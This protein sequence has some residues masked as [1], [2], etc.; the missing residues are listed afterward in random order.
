MHP[1]DTARAAP[2]LA[3]SDP[4][5]C[6]LRPSENI[7]FKSAPH[8]NQALCVCGIDP[9]LSGGLAFFFPGAPA[10]VLAEDLPTVAGEID[11]AT[12]AARIRQMRPDVAFVERVASMPGQ[13]VSST[14]KFGAAY[15]C[16][17][18][19]L[20]ALEIRTHLVAP[21]IWKKHFQL[22]S[23]KEKARALALRT[24]AKTPGHFSRKRDH[25]R[26]EAALLAL[27]GATIN[28]PNQSQF[29]DADR[30][31]RASL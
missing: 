29:A 7:S 20:A 31:A 12:L 22:D 25:N 3:G 19:V 15:G 5:N 18:G 27:Y 28:L 2:A 23:D 24:F 14:F 13:G 1:P 11:C 17:R 9:G 8:E 26:A 10:R 30:R 16:I 6:S 4:R 21:G